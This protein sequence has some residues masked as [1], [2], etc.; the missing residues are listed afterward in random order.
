MTRQ[1]VGRHVSSGHLADQVAALQLD[2]ATMSHAALTSA[3]MRLHARALALLTAA[4]E[5]RDG[6]TAAS[7]IREARRTLETISTFSLRT[8]E[9]VDE[10]EA[11]ELDA[12]IAEALDARLGPP[13]AP[14][15]DTPPPH[16]PP[17]EPLA[18]EAGSMAP[19]PPIPTGKVQ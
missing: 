18:L 17:L 12:R 6:K 19:P 2:E 9:Q 13:S 10:S 5:E 1:A 3:A 11:P 4:E 7:M 8:P 14:P 16:S 15:R